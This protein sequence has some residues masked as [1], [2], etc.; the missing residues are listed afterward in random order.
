M[1]LKLIITKYAQH[2][3]KMVVVVVVSVWM[4][5]QKLQCFDKGGKP[6]I[7]IKQNKT[8]KEK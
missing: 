4:L 8:K 6:S 2:L 3:H 5:P 1:W 7:K